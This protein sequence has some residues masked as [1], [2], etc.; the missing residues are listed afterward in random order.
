MTRTPP[1][2]GALAVSRAFGGASLALLERIAAQAV[3]RV[4]A[5]G[6]TV[7]KAGASASQLGVVTSGLVR[8]HQP[9]D[10][11]DTALAIFG[12]RETVG[13]LAVCD[14]GPYPVTAVAAVDDTWVARVDTAIVRELMERD[15][16]VANGMIRALAD[17]ARALHTKLGIARA[18]SVEKRL[19]VLFLHLLERFGDQLPDGSWVIPVALS[20][21]ELAALVDSTI[22][23]TIRTASRWQ[24]RGLLSTSRDGFVVPEPARLGAILHGA[25]SSRRIVA[26]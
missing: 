24:K 6:E 3:H 15:L 14:G 5:R 19:V 23:T 16:A 20:R 4:Y 25:P 7:F 22:E 10:E 8:V 2:I 18:G 17:H 1:L 11:E 21:A 13:N 26:A 12:P 9:S